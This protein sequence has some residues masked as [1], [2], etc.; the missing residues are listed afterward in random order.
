MDAA[1]HV[2]PCEISLDAAT[3]KLCGAR[4]YPTTLLESHLTRHHLKRRQFKAELKKLR[5]IMS[6]MRDIK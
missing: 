1:I 3:C 5:F 6:R 4:I 2:Q